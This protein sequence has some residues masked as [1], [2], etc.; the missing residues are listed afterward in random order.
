MSAHH[1][2]IYTTRVIYNRCTNSKNYRDSYIKVMHLTDYYNLSG[3]LS[4]YRIV[5]AL[6]QVTL[7]LYSCLYTSNIGLYN[8]MSVW[9][10]LEHTASLRIPHQQIHILQQP[11]AITFHHKNGTHNNHEGKRNRGK[12]I[13]FST[14]TIC[15]IMGQPIRHVPR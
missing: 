3:S 13:P 4:T 5:K 15:C 6:A 12:N 11:S 7:L 10:S 1:N 2:H 9:P 14:E 8:Y